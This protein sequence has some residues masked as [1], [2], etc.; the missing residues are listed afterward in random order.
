LPGRFGI[1]DLGDEAYK[2]V[3]F[4][5]ASSQS[6]WQV[7]PLGPTGYGDSPYQCFSALAG[8]PLL[9]SPERLVE[10][11]LL[12]KEDLE[13]VPEFPVERVNYGL[14]IDFKN[15]LLRKAFDR[16]K[17]MNSQELQNDF[18]A[19]CENSAS[20]LEGY[21]LFSAL[22]DAHGGEGWNTWGPEL[23]RRDPEALAARREELSDSI[24]AKKFYQYLFFK[25]W[26]ALKNYCNERGI[27]IIG[28]MP[29]FVAYD[30]VDLWEHPDLFKL[31]KNC[32]MTVVAGVPPDFFSETGQLWGNPLYNWNKMRSKGYF[33]WVERIKG[34][35]QLFDIIRL[36]HFRGFSACWE[37][38]AADK[39]AARGRWV[40]VPGRGLFT[41]L[42]GVFGELPIIA[43]DL[44][45]ITPDVETLRDDFKLP[46]M[47]VL[48]FAFNG[49][50]KNNHLPHHYVRNM[51]V[52]TGTH[53]NDTTVGWFKNI[54]TETP[55]GKHEKEYCMKYL[56][57]D[58]HGIH[59]DFIQA[60][61]A[62]VA[63][64]A[65]IPVQDLLGLD[66]SGR[67]NLPASDQGNWN[68][69]LKPGALVPE[70]AETLRAMTEIYGRVR[71][72]EQEEK[73]EGEEQ[74]VELGPATVA[75]ATD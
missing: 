38:P 9:I 41:T 40:H 52:Y 7:L 8:N 37:V 35:L 2:F 32:K 50:S 51:V 10:G 34:L 59:G 4:L 54:N 46:G 67:M 61:L 75:Q 58:G 49:D 24:E 53:D 73:K 44:G 14:V 71:V 36:D 15:K 64:T 43:E 22:K 33:W 69:R 29:I 74:S 45:V 57:S 63:N 19:F 18:K 72:V 68:W 11:G 12:S 20:W 31:D 6:L 1:G 27:K 28:D 13:K 30:S 16:Y 55:Q 60:A 48:Q 42:K 26:S 62:S 39:T 56:K 70:M 47:R 66:S 17:Q 3:D 21:A 25:Q 5:V 65:I 23:I